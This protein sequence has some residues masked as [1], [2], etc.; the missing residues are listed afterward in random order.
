MS[1]GVSES[2]DEVRKKLARLD[3]FGGELR[4]LS[5]GQALDHEGTAGKAAPFEAGEHFWK[6]H[7]AGAGGEVDRFGRFEILNAHADHEAVDRRLAQSGPSRAL[8]DWF[9]AWR[10]SAATF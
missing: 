4:P 5:G 3:G 7:L 2:V 6:V 9:A 1:L 8:T 10:E